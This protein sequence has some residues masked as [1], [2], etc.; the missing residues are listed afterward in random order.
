MYVC[1]EIY[2]FLILCQTRVS[3]TAMEVTKR[4]AQHQPHAAHATSATMR[5]SASPVRDWR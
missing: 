3:Q 1:A 5:R 4:T 2:D